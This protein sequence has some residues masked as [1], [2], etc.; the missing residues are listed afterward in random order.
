[1]DFLALIDAELS[2]SAT[3][4]RC[5]VEQNAGLQLESIQLGTVV[6][7]DKVFLVNKASFDLKLTGRLKDLTFL[8]IAPSDDA[9]AIKKQ[10]E[11]AG[12]TFL[13]DTHIYVKNV[14]TRVMVFGK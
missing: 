14:V 9:A 2:L 4:K 12:Q 6:K 5:E 8:E 7:N 10:H 13:C 3:E 1:M 11:N